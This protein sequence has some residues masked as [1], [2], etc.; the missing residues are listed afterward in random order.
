M[1]TDTSIDQKILPLQDRVLVERVDPVTK[2]AGGVILP[3]TSAEKPGEGI[4]VA[5]GPGLTKDD[6]NTKPVTVKIG[7]RVIFQKHAGTELKFESKVYLMLR[8]IDIHAI[9]KA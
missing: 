1:T 8:E 7:D 3:D 2:S 9:I 4:V 5:V 6:G